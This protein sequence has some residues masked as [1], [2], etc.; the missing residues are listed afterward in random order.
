MGSYTYSI[1]ITRPDIAFT[2]KQLAKSLQNP[3]PQHF[4]IAHKCL[5][6]LEATKHYAIKLRTLCTEHPIFAAA[7][8]AA[9][10]DNLITRRSTKGSI[11]QLFGGTIDWQSKKQATVTTSTTE[12]K[13]LALS[14]IS[15]WLL[16]WGRLFLNINLDI[17]QELTVHCDNLQIVGLIIKDSP[18]LITKLKHINIHQH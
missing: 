16:W 15:A 1:A 14:H 6:Y 13:L 8:D 12:A 3:S 10:A 5:D 17:K 2:T 9:Y 11:F 4:D 18:K 7:S